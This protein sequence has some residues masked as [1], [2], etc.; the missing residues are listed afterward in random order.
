M[1]ICLFERGHITSNAN[2]LGQLQKQKDLLEEAKSLEERT[3]RVNP[4]LL[5]D[6]GNAYGQLGHHGHLARGKRIFGAWPMVT[7]WRSSIYLSIYRSIDRSIYLSIYLS[8]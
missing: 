7:L 2:A 4:D 6:L 1:I 5:V 3:G 8:N